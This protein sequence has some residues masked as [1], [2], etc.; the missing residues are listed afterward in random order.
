MKNKDYT[1]LWIALLGVLI[2]SIIVLVVYFASGK[3]YHYGVMWILWF[4]IL[5]VVGLVIAKY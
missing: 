2:F 5:S 1:P 4:C 3:I